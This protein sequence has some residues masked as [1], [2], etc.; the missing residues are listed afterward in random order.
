MEASV[1]QHPS[2]ARSTIERVFRA[3]H[4]KVIA[5]LIGTLGDFDVAEEALQEALTVALER[6]PRDGIP[7][8]PPRGW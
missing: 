6:W 5:S 8:N 2:D 3:E 4:G 1:R 7:P